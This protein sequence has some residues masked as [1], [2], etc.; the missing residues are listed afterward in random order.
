ME[1]SKDK[2]GWLV[3]SKLV[4]NCVIV[5]ILG[6][7]CKIVIHKQG[8]GRVHPFAKNCNSL[9]IL[10]KLQEIQAHLQSCDAV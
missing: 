5:S 8:W 7:G 6:Y 2:T 10:Q 3:I 9:S 4:I 1:H